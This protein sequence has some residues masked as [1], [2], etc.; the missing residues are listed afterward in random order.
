MVSRTQ[1]AYIGLAFLA[2]IFGL[3]VRFELYNSQPV[4]FAHDEVLSILVAQGNTRAIARDGERYDGRWVAARDWTKHLYQPGERSFREIANDLAASD[5]HPPLYFWT[6]RLWI[7]AFGAENARLLNLPIVVATWF[8][9]F[10][11]ARN[12]LGAVL[13]ASLAVTIWVLNPQ[14]IRVSEYA[15][16]YELLTLITVLLAWQTARFCQGRRSPI[17]FALYAGLACAGMLTHYIFALPIIAS[18]VI[19]AIGAPRLLVFAAAALV[20]AA[21]LFMLIHPTF[22]EQLDRKGSETMDVERLKITAS[23]LLNFLGWRQSWTTLPIA[24]ATLSVAAVGAVVGAFWIA[25]RRSQWIAL[26]FF[27][28]IGIVF[29]GA[30]ILALMPQHAM[31]ARYVSF[32]W[33]FPAIIGAAVVCYLVPRLAAFLL[34]VFA[35]ILAPAMFLLSLDREP[36]TLD[37]YFRNAA[38]VVINDV[39]AGNLLRFILKMPDGTAI[40]AKKDLIGDDGWLD[41][42]QPS[43]VILLHDPDD[44]DRSRA[45]ALLEFVRKRRAASVSLQRYNTTIITID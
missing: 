40:F 45:K 25:Q 43:D 5:I 38:R 13:P 20:V 39:S 17:D 28:T 22:Y 41:D 2:L 27:L 36:R 21:L 26:C 30:Y 16:Q 18:L 1:F 3:L 29:V 19:L 6:L 14:V 12:Q 44:T 10:G 33:P 42:L 4:P 8:A 34:P 24:V 32:L 31:A 37:P 9:L 15:R 23:Q 7:G 35:G 11:F